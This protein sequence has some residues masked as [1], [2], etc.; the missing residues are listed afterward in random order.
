MITAHEIRYND[1]FQGLNPKSFSMEQ[2][3]H[4]RYPHTAAAK[5]KIG[6]II[7][8]LESPEAVFSFEIFDK[9]EN[10]TFW[11]VQLNTLQSLGTVRSLVWPGYI[12]YCLFNN[13]VFGGVYYGNGL[14]QT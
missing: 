4:F 9:V 1:K 11:S 6:K 3:V 12:S 5:E 14:K 13:R 8:Y 2:F 7:G 10:K